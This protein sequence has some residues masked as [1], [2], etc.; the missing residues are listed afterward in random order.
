MERPD[1][2]IVLLTR[3]LYLVTTYA[4]GQRD[5]DR[6]AELVSAEFGQQLTPAALMYLVQQ[7]LRPPGIVGRSGEAPAELRRVD[8]LLGVN[9]RAVLAPPR[10]G[11]SPWA[12]GWPR[13]SARA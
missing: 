8:P 10:V 2:Q 4:D 9:L 12:V 5:T 13:C 7:K 11:L 6:V 3:L 1:G